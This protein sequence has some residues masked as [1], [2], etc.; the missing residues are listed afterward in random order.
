MLFRSHRDQ[1]AFATAGSSAREVSVERVDR[2]SV[3]CVDRLRKHQR[4]GHVRLDVKDGALLKE[5]RD[6]DRVLL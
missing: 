3:D 1:S 4:L 5:E 6:Q 2:S